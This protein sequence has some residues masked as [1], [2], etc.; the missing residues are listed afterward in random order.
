MLSSPVAA[1]GSV[2][3]SRSPSQDKGDPLASFARR[4]G[5]EVV[6]RRV[7]AA[8]HC[9]SA[10]KPEGWLISANS[11]FIVPAEL[12]EQFEGRSL[13]FHPGLLPEYAGLH[14]HQW[15]IRNGEREFG[16]TV[17]R[18]E[19]AIDTGP[20]V[21][22]VRFPVKPDDTGL[23]LYSRCL[24]AG[25]ELFSRIAG[26]IVR[27]EPL[28]EIPPGPDAPPALPASRCSGGAH[29]LELE[30]QPRCRFYP[31]R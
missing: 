15:A 17:H 4:L 21:G 14:T 29:C 13:N 19:N 8:E 22:Q 5:I 10:R 16:V 20:I 24:T 3:P 26:K 18:M 30:R 2:P 7:F 6:G 11:A 23:S 27:G 25:A 9:A 12:L 31:R 28:A 1:T